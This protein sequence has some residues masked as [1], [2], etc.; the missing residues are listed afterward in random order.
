MFLVGVDIDTGND[1]AVFLYFSM[2]LANTL[3]AHWSR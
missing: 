2:V 1:L 3:F